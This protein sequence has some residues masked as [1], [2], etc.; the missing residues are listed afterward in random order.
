MI[1]EINWLRSFD[2]APMAS[3]PQALQLTEEVERLRSQLDSESQRHSGLRLESE[4]HF[5]QLR[6]ELDGLRAEQETAEQQREH[7]E[8]IVEE[9]RAE[10]VRLRLAV[11]ELELHKESLL[12]QSS[13]HEGTIG[14]LK[15]QVW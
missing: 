6:G 15:S 4:N 11:S 12:F 5:G 7:L 3:C 2:A 14:S 8:R 1:C 9:Q 13:S 10:L